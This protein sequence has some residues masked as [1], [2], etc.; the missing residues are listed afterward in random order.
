MDKAE[1]NQVVECSFYKNVFATSQ[2]TLITLNQYINGVKESRYEKLIRKLRAYVAAGDSEKAEQYKKNFPLL[3]V[4]GGMEGGRRL[5]HLVRYS[6]CLCIDLDDV[7]GSAEDVLCLAEQLPYVKAGHVSPSGTGDKLFVLV[8]SDLAHHPEAFDYVS[9]R[10]E[11]DLPGVTVD[12]SGKDPNRGCF[13]SSDPRAFYKEQAEVLH[14]P[15]SSEAPP[16]SP[17][18]PP[19]LRQQQGF[20]LQNYIDKFQTGN[21]FSGGGRHTY[22][23]KLASALNSAGFPER[24]V[25][26]ECLR[27]YSEPG[28]GE[29]EIRAVVADIYNR[30][31]SAH[32]SN[33]WTGTGE[34]LTRKS[35]KN[36]KNP[37]PIP[38]STPFEEESSEGI[39]IEPEDAH[40]PHFDRGLMEH[41]PTLLSDVLKTAVDDAEYDIL[42]LGALT[43][44][45]TALPGV[46]G[47][48]KKIPY[49]P[50]F[51][52]LIIGP[53]GSGKGCISPLFQLVAAWQ[54]YVYDNSHCR[55]LEYKKKK[56]E[57][58]TYK[59]QERQGKYKKT[60]G[61]PP[62]N[63]DPVRQMVLHI[64]GYT[65][66]AR[67]I[68]Q[69]EVN[70]G[71]A[72]L[73]F[74]TELESI[75][76]TLAQDFG[77]YGYVLNQAFH[78]E[79]IS[80]ASKTNGSFRVEHPVLG[81]LATGTP[82]MLQQL[83][84]S[85]ESG[86][87]SRL[88]I[89][90]LSGHM[91]YRPLTSADSV[92][93]SANYFD[94]LGQRMLDMAIHLEEHPTFVS[95]SDKQRKRLDRYFE[96]EYNNARVFS[97]D[98]VVSVVLRHRLIIFRIAMV[99]SAL[100]K[101]ECGST[102]RDWEIDDCDFEVAL[103]I[104]ACCLRHSL[105]VSTSLRHSDPVQSYKLPTNQLDLFASMLDEFKTLTILEA[106]S[107]R[108]ISRSTVF[109]M[110]KKAE[111]YGL[112]VS[113]GGGCYRKTEAGKNIVPPKMG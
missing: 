102:E 27:R 56:E 100:R 2:P 55:V 43:A 74:E 29:K 50:A 38:G 25:T 15:L 83:I 75:N 8:D 28:F 31:R 92:A 23:V 13:V 19:A 40:L 84:P 44:I 95:F 5:E 106:A 72:S 48:L 37:D 103:H 99:L 89:Y 59:I 108:K 82:G 76:N 66:T 35:L 78:H 3:V 109:R 32:G 36:P 12:P 79:Q 46:T 26:D 67:M 47:L 113:L 39:D 86:L 64:G 81:M 110:L 34:D 21:T 41:L 70:G 112:V 51:Y 91:A 71:Y 11:T 58:E 30:Y 9:H 77:G 73:L 105:L 53:S 52:T 85:I 111:Q 88:L 4:G 1:I 61:L 7:P 42:L 93:S 57:Y 96:R 101:A 14:I 33:P 10:V 68:E 87:Y 104:G 17:L 49:S 62:E 60:V 16:L 65:T 98:D 20:P 69:L 18:T 90:R 80:C 54:R 24:E 107:V 6:H 45:S 63:P 97:N 94:T 22:L